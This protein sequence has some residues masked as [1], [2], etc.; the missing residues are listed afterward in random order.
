MIDANL[1]LI[2]AKIYLAIGDLLGVYKV[3]TKT[4]VIES[5][6]I[7]VLEHSDLAYE[8]P[9]EGTGLT[10][11]ECVIVPATVKPDPLIGGRLLERNYLILLFQRDKDKGV[12]EAIDRLLQTDLQIVN[13]GVNIDIETPKSKTYKVASIT[14]RYHSQVKF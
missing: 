12:R 9:I 13:N 6:A 4:G 10:G 8:Y 1:V 3:P 11:L 7:T 2:R 14:V 5:E